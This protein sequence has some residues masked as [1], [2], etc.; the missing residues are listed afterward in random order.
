[1]KY[2]QR[3]TVTDWLWSALARVILITGWTLAIGFWVWV[4]VSALFD[5]FG[6]DYYSQY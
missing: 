3:Q 1:M 5:P 6:G 4:I 2:L